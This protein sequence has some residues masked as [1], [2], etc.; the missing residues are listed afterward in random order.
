[1]AMVVIMALATTGCNEKAE[2]GTALNDSLSE[3]LGEFA[4]K[5]VNFQSQRDSTLDKDLFLKGV[6][7]ALNAD[8]AR[9]YQSGL[10]FA[11]QIMADVQRMEQEGVKFSKTLFINK[12]KAAFKGD[13]I[14]EQEL[15]ELQMTYQSLAQRAI[16]EAKANSPKAKANLEEGKKFLEK[17]AKENGYKKTASGIV[18]KVTKEGAGENFKET[19]KVLVNY[20]GKHINGQEFDSNKGQEPVPFDMKGVIP[21]FAEMLK[22]MK[23]GD[24]VEVIIPSELAYGV[25]GKRNPMTGQE[26]IG[27]NETLIFEME[28]VGKAPQEPAKPEANVPVPAPAPQGK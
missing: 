2:K 13:S 22:L 1:M 4:G 18:Y 23:P 9:S 20:V 15:Q 17:K 6:Q 7:D 8:T 11:M 5:I 3:T 28:A 25:D 24:K 26:N 12:F 14:N 19:D 10:N 16:N 21:G 27:P